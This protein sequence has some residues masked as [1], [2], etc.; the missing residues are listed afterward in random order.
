MARRRLMSLLGV[1]LTGV[2][3]AA[4]TGGSPVDQAQGPAIT[5]YKT[6][7]CGCCGKW[8]DHMKKAGFAVRTVDTDDLTEVKQASGVPMRLRTCHTALVEGYVIEGHVPADLVERLLKEKPAGAGL[9]VAGM[10]MGS[11]GMEGVRRD[12]YEVLLFSKDGKTTVYAKR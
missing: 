6:A 3:V 1:G 9:A 10:P 5:V 7:T 11:P 2:A 4:T 12:A 8:V